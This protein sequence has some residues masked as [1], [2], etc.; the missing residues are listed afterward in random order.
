MVVKY[1]DEFNAIGNQEEIKIGA[2][3]FSAP[4]TALCANF[5]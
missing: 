1:K 5:L 3:K 2:L 4:E